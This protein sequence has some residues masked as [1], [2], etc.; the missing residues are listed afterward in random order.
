MGELVELVVEFSDSK[1]SLAQ[2]RRQLDHSYTRVQR[3]ATSPV[4]NQVAH[5]IRRMRITRVRVGADLIR[6]EPEFSAGSETQ[7]GAIR[8]V[9]ANRLLNTAVI[10]GN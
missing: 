4:S 1:P 2:L 3:Y 5:A 9:S 8:Q 10:S 6:R 7:N